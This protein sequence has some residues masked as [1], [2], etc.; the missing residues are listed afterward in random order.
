MKPQI[1]LAKCF[2]GLPDEDIYEAKFPLMYDGCL[3]SEQWLEVRVTANQIG[4]PHTVDLTVVT[5]DGDHRHP[6]GSFKTT[7]M[8]ALSH[9]LYGVAKLKTI[10]VLESR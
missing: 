4:N 8:E 1:T 5:L 9:L 6:L 3:D 10:Q 2:V 7:N